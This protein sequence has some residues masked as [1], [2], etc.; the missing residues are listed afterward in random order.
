MT[1]KKDDAEKG[2]VGRRLLIK[3]RA[4]KISIANYFWQK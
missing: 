2:M 4:K 1:G 3:L